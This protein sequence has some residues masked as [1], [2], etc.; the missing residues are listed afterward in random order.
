[1]RLTPIATD[2][3]D[4]IFKG[5]G[6]LK[7]KRLAALLDWVGLL[8]DTFPNTTEAARLQE[9]RGTLERGPLS[10]SAGASHKGGGSGSVRAKEGAEVVVEKASAAA[11]QGGKPKAAGTTAV[12]WTPALYDSVLSD[13]GARPADDDDWSS[14]CSSGQQGALVAGGDAAAAAMGSSGGYLLAN[15]LFR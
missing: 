3:V 9:L 8:V 7:G 1:M 11:L 14:W 2:Q 13:W 6:A 4:S 15:A 10:A 12:V 5:K